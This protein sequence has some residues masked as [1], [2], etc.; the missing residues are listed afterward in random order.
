M[1]ENEQGRVTFYVRDR[2]TFFITHTPV[3][4]HE[5]IPKFTGDIIWATVSD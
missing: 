4:F 2:I 5:T 1:L 3:K